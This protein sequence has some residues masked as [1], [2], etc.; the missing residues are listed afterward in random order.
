MKENHMHTG[1][2]IQIMAAKELGA[3]Y[4]EASKELFSNPEILAP[5]LHEVVEEYKDCT[6]QEIISY[7]DKSS[8]VSDPVDAV[9]KLAD[10]VQEL[11]TE[12]NSLGEKLTRY[13]EHFICINPKLTT[14][15]MKVYLHMDFEIQND[16]QPGNPKYP[17]IKR[18]IFY[19][20][21]EISSQLGILTETTD[22]SKIQ[23]VYSIWVCNENIP[24]AL[25]NTVSSYAVTK[26]DLIGNTDEPKQD[27]DLLTVIIIRRGNDEQSPQNQLFDYLTGIFQSDIQRINKYVDINDNLKVMEGVKNMSGLGQSIAE[28]SYMQGESKGREK[29]REEGSYTM[30]YSLVQDGDITPEKGAKKLGISI[31]QLKANMVNLGY[32]LPQ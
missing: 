14:Q 5:I 28:K 4:D 13:D 11:P 1:T 18:G 26:K 23:K 16:Y 27:Y 19:G 2:K 10:K 21:R 3:K 12:L 15:K 32:K 22:Y 31:E 8:I 20:T 25:Q 6:I 9:S 7:I 29:G 17:L 30:V 24:Q